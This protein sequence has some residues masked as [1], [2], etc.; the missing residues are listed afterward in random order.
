[1][2]VLFTAIQTNRTFT[3]HQNY[4]FPHKNNKCL[5]SSKTFWEGKM[6]VT[7]FLMVQNQFLRGLG[8]YI[9]GHPTELIWESDNK[10][11]PLCVKPILMGTAQACTQKW[12]KKY[13][14][15]KLLCIQH[16]CNMS[17]YSHYWRLYWGV[18]WSLSN[19]KFLSE[20]CAS[21]SKF[22]YSGALCLCVANLRLELKRAPVHVRSCK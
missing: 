13:L 11:T 7:N 18:Y 21:V 17:L 16:N 20:Q 2:S 19:F 8:Q 1:M 12:Q 14:Y 3:L 10:V 9:V 15:R 6:V 4:N 22:V 5:S